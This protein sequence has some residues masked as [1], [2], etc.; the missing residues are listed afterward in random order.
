M[1]RNIWSGNKAWIDCFCDMFKASNKKRPFPKLPMSSFERGKPPE[2]KA[3]R[4]T[5]S[6]GLSG[7]V[8]CS[9]CHVRTSSASSRFLTIP[10]PSPHLPGAA[11]NALILRSLGWDS[12]G[13]VKVVKPKWFNLQG[14]TTTSLGV[15]D[16]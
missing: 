9:E 3:K 6:Q 14:S 11:Q 15:F 13:R 8:E 10:V 1:I 5:K 4:S 2:T 7:P 12:L 16:T